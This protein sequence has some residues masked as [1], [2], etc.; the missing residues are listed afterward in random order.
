MP[1]GALMKKLKKMTSILL[2]MIVVS[3]LALHSVGCSGAQ[4]SSEPDSGPPPVE[5]PAMEVEVPDP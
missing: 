5:D 4:N 3:G 2:M 1:K